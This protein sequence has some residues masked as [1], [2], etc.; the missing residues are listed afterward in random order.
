VRRYSL[1]LCLSL[2]PAVGFAQ[3]AP[4]ILPAGDAA[5]AGFSGTIVVGSPPEP[6][7]T[8]KTYIN[9][10]GP[11]LR[12]IGL[13]RLGGPPQGQFVPAA[14]P[15]AATA[16]QIGQVFSVALDDVDPPNVY[17]AATSAYG[18]PIV[19]PD[20]DGDGVPDRA[21]R[22]A[23]NAAFMPGLFGPAI[24]NGG[25][26]SIWKIDGRTG[27]VS[28]FANVI[29]AGVP[30]SGPALGGLAF[31][32]ASRQI[33]VADRD[34]GMIHRFTLEGVD[35]GQFDH[36]VQGLA[37][38]QLPPAAFDPRKRINLQDPAFD[39]TKPATWGYPPIVRRVFGLGVYNSRL[40]YA[41]ASGLRI[42]SVAIMPDGSFGTD[43]RIE[44]A[45]PSGPQ[46]SAE[47]S[48]IAFDREGR[49]LLAE[50]D[51]PTGAY[52]Y[53]VLA[54]PAGGRALR[55]SA[56]QP[57]ENR[58]PFYWQPDGDYA[59]GF[60]P[61]FTN[62]DGGLA[63]GYGYDS[64]GNIDRGSCGASLWTTGEQLRLSRDRS[65]A[66]RLRATGAEAVN[67]LQGNALE[68]VRPQNAPPFNSY[69]MS[70]IDPAE[71]PGLMGQIGG[72]AIWQTCPR[73]EFFLPPEMLA[74]ILEICPPGYESVRDQCVPTPCKPDERYRDGKCV[75]ECP[76]LRRSVR[77]ECCPLGSIFDGRRC[78]QP[79]GPDLTITKEIDRC[80]SNECYYTITVKNL[81]P[82]T[83]NGELIVADVSTAGQITSTSF[84]WVCT[85]GSLPNGSPDLLCKRPNT[86]IPPGQSVKLTI[87]VTG[88]NAATGGLLNCAIVDPRRD[89]N[90]SNNIACKYRPPPPPPPS[91]GNPKLKIVKDKPKEC[92][93]VNNDGNT[94]VWQCVFTVTVTNDGTAPANN[95]T[96]TDQPVTGTI[97]DV[98]QDGSWNCTNGNNSVT[99]RRPTLAAGPLP[100]SFKVT[101]EISV[102]N[103]DP[104]APTRGGGVVNFARNC[105]AIGETVRR[106]DLLD[107]RVQ[108]ASY[109]ADPAFAFRLAQAQG[110]LPGS[111]VSPGSGTTPPAPPAAPGGT[112]V[113]PG[114]VITFPGGAPNISLDPLLGADQQ[115]CATIGVPINPK[116]PPPVTTCTPTHIPGCVC[117]GSPIGPQNLPSC[118]ADE[119]MTT[120]PGSGTATACPGDLPRNSDGNCP[121]PPSTIIP[122]PP[123]IVSCPFPTF[124][125]NGT[126]CTRE[127]VTAGTCGTR[128]SGC[129][130]G[131]TRNSDGNCPTP[132]SCQ[133]PN[134]LV[135]GACCNIR[136]VQTGRCGGPQPGSGSQPVCGF[137]KTL[138]NGQCVCRGGTVG[139]DCHVPPGT[140]SQPACQD[141]A[142]RKADGSCCGPR[143]YAVG[144]CARPSNRC[145]DGSEKKPHALCPTKGDSKKTTCGRGMSLV[146][147]EC[148]RRSPNLNQKNNK[149][150]DAQKLRSGRNV[151]TAPL[152]NAIGQGSKSSGSHS[153]SKGN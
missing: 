111:T 8:D 89:G 133:P 96:V 104:S 30:N 141:G 84:D 21:R 83:Y 6:Q 72:I 127:A 60:P 124:L 148:V 44:M 132:T 115:S 97:V 77:N 36:G 91:S 87:K 76:V 123:T 1:V 153:K 106:G 150:S 114:G 66:A 20:A 101:V 10:D 117:A 52:D 59:L 54:T 45:V 139:D 55:F 73:A 125:V 42:W 118:R 63:L 147:G 47:I 67:G 152:S 145:P 69:F 58:T 86:S 81:G 2:L 98:Q 151:N 105:A 62:G 26:G 37:A 109:V 149:P 126:C 48:T 136:E 131:A 39:S 100:A 13:D 25:P 146:N 43:A 51:P 53:T 129:P 142:A 16:R 108:I 135:N 12:V 33:F 34:T 119:C 22:G 130:G 38:A 74:G 102:G 137:P 138:I 7:R 28:L 41:V 40:Y 94:S 14:K 93:L 128:V 68:L 57:G 120:C 88:I 49:M 31:D 17:A 35:R 29:L 18:L 92:T 24:A 116:N 134:F 46:S 144:T 4:P 50:R 11:A 3:N 56:K 71:Q 19:V 27:A 121:P 15:F 32:P 143:D 103:K 112:V 113:D 85:Q 99:C 95:V 122:P 64:A 78:V 65:I 75:H 9:L 61:N 23:P 5:V 110:V 80:G 90:T 140:G 79:K 70:Y 107:R 82:G